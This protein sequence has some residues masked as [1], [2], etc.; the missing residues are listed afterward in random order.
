MHRLPEAATVVNDCC[1]DAPRK[2]R[3]A[4][5]IR[6][7]RHGWVW[8]GRHDPTGGKARYCITPGAALTDLRLNLLQIRILGHIGRYKG[9]VAIDQAELAHWFG[10]QRPK[11]ST[12]IKKLIA[13]GYMEGLTQSETVVPQAVV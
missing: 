9:W 8:D 12:A 7:R 10:T 11:V 2:P 13:L 4:C 6:S 3:G 5:R 1:G